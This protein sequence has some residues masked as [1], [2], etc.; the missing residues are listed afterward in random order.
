MKKDF[1]AQAGERIK[2]LEKDNR[3]LENQLAQLKKDF[4]MQ[5]DEFEKLISL[6]NILIEDL[7]NSQDKESQKQDDENRKLAILVATLSDEIEELKVKI[8][9]DAT[10]FENELSAKNEEIRKLITLQSEQNKMLDESNSQIEVLKAEITDISNRENLLQK[11]LSDLIIHLREEFLNSRNQLTGKDTEIRRLREQLERQ[12]ELTEVVLKSTS[13]ENIA[14][15]RL[16]IDNEFTEDKPLYQ[17]YTQLSVLRKECETLLEEKER[18]QGNL[19]ATKKNSFSLRDELEKTKNNKIVA[20]Y[21]LKEFERKI[22]NLAEDKE[23]IEIELPKLTK[24]K[25][26]QAETQEELLEIRA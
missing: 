20:K 6:K 7:R 25:N 24:E 10:G 2:F 21:R 26:G 19:N 5:N 14:A 4:T 15:L 9:P 1:T 17:I 16:E 13:G 3:I 12:N 23:E 8:S 22:Q 18:I 11:D